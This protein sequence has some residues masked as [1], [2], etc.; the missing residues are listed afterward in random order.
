LSNSESIIFMYYVGDSGESLNSETET[1]ETIVKAHK[2]ILSAKNSVLVFR[3]L[4]GR[5]RSC[6][7]IISALKHIS[8]ELMR[9]K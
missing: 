7:P 5:L 9:R 8:G 1:T 6:H 4:K 2:F 3:R